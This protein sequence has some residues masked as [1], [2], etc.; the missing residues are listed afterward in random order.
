MTPDEFAKKMR[1]KIES[2]RTKNIPLKLSV[3]TS[4]AQVSTRAFTNKLNEKGEFFRY[5]SLDPLYI[6]DEQSPRKLNH[7]GKF[8]SD[9][10]KSGK[11]KGQ[12]HKTTYFGSYKEFRAAVGAD[13]EAVDWQLTNDLRS[14]Y[15]NASK[16]APPSK[17]KPAVQVNVNNYITRLSREHNIKKYEGLSARYGNFLTCSEKEIQDYFRILDL[18]LGN[19]LAK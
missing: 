11:K 17:L 13:S 10:F 9:T 14:D 3:A 18:E 15:G 2:L 7:K 1:E 6:R 16:A 8:G 12:K 5:N 4:V 19:F